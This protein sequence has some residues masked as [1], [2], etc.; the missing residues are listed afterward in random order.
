ML[1]GVLWVLCSGAAWRD[2][3]ERLQPMVEGVSALS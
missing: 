3:P 2:T 1:T